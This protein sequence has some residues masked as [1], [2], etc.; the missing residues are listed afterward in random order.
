MLL[1]ATQLNPGGNGSD[2]TFPHT[3][4]TP[5]YP[6]GIEIQNPFTTT[7]PI[8]NNA[9]FKNIFIIITW[10]LFTGIFSG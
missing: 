4:F 7:I 9:N 2:S 10:L 3:V 5:T 8:K 1:V 6:V